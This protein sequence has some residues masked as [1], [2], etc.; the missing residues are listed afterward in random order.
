MHEF[1][2][3]IARLAFSKGAAFCYAVAVGVSGQLAYNY[4]QPRDPAPRSVSVA[5]PAPYAAPPSGTAAVAPIPRATPPEPAPAPASVA[6]APSVAITNPASA[7]PAA[8]API[9]PEPGHC[10]CRAWPRCPPPS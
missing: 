9:L 4:L 5:A 8:T 6:S 2:A 1:F 10:R 3:K 7:P